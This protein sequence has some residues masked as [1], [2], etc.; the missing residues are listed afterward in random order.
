MGSLNDLQ[1]QDVAAQKML[2]FF[3]LIPIMRVT[4][5]TQTTDT[6]M[7]FSPETDIILEQSSGDRQRSGHGGD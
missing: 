6:N 5:S 4:V 3:A 2:H 1:P 7:S